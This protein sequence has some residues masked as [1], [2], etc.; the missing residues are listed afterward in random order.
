MKVSEFLRKLSS[1]AKRKGVS[2]VFVPA[3]GKGSHGTVFFG[4]A[5]TTVKDSKKEIG[6]GLL[7]A[8]CKSLGI[9]PND[10]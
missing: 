2:C 6:A 5:F 7:K 10:L 1:L 3:K 4:S 9:D 8:M